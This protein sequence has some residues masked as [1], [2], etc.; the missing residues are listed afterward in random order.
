MDEQSIQ[1]NPNDK[2]IIIIDK[3]LPSYPDFDHFGVEWIPYDTERN[4]TEEDKGYLYQN[5]TRI[6]NLL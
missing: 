6:K 5:V 2:V 3:L 4:W 1:S